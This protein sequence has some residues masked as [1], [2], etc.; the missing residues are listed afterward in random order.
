MAEAART[1]DIKITMECT[2]DRECTAASETKWR[3]KWTLACMQKHVYPHARAK[4][5]HASWR[6]TANVAQA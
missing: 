2:N 5:A 6:V 1:P 4:I 3:L